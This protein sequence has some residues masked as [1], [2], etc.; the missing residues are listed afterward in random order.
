MYNKASTGLKI[1][2]ND[3][4]SFKKGRKEI[5]YETYFNS[6]KKNMDLN[7]AVVMDNPIIKPL[8]CED[9]GSNHLE[10]ISELDKFFPADDKEA[11]YF[12]VKE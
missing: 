10:E 2:N 8:N 4:F 6:E 11:F 1:L 9:I 5:G 12:S 3:Y 7:K